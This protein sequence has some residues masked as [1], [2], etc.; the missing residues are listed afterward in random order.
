MRKDEGGAGGVFLMMNSV[1]GEW[2]LTINLP[3]IIK[4]T[5][6]IAGVVFLMMNTFAGQ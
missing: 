5:P 3:V 1:G 2:S 6:P 4:P